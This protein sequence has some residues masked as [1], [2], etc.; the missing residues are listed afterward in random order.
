LDSSWTNLAQVT[1]AAPAGKMLYL[2]GFATLTN[3]SP[4]TPMQYRLTSAQVI[5]TFN[6][7]VPD[8]MSDGAHVAS[9][10]KPPGTGNATYWFQAKSLGASFTVGARELVVQT[11]PS[12]TLLEAGGGAVSFPNDFQWHTIA[13]SPW[14]T[15]PGA[16]RGLYGSDGSGYAY[17]THTGS[18]SLGEVRL[19]LETTYT[20]PY[21]HWEVGWLGVNPSGYA[22]LEGDGSD[23]EQLGLD[24]GTNFRMHLQ[25]RGL[26]PSDPRPLSISKSRFQ[27]MIVPDNLPFTGASCA[28]NPAV[29][30]ASH[31]SVCQKYECKMLL[32]LQPWTSAGSCP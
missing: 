7:S 25:V 10:Y 19:D 3:G 4:L 30:C 28:A 22:R 13:Q 9:I 12:F 11:L 27:V 21:D 2:A 18:A 29:C 16:A 24:V 8:V 26:C 1:I 23:W 15:L 5:D 20:P 14:I 31:P 17:F 32:G 6:D